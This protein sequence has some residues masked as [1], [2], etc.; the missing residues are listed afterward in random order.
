MQLSVIGCAMRISGRNR[1]T[2][3]LPDT[4]APEVQNAKRR[5]ELTI[6]IGMNRRNWTSGITIGA[7]AGVCV[8]T[9]MTFLDWRLN[10]GGIFHGATGTNWTIVLET[11]I[12]WFAPVAGAGAA[13]AL[14]VLFVWARL[15]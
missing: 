6:G 7:I 2:T 13:V 5:I 9:I 15:R 11:A 14:V 3:D 4:H 1:P 12:S 10:P 8:A